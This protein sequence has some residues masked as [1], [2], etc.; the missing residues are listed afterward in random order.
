MQGD[1]WGFSW[2]VEFKYLSSEF[3]KTFLEETDQL[4]RNSGKCLASE[5]TAG[6]KSLFSGGGGRGS[7]GPSCCNIMIKCVEKVVFFWCACVRGGTR[8][9][10]FSAFGSVFKIGW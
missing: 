5:S 7:Y 1:K 6:E 8:R 3:K 2:E 10:R 4:V 9:E